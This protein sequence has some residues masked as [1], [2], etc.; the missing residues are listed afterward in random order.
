M[1]EFSE[2]EKKVYDALIDNKQNEVSDRVRFIESLISQAGSYSISLPSSDEMVD[3]YQKLNE[4]KI[5]KMNLKT[6]PIKNLKQV[7]HFNWDNVFPK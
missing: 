2:L 3:R 7:L 6:Q 5:I 4:Q 1:D